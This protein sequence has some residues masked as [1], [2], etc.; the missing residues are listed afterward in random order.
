MI[1]NY[2]IKGVQTLKGGVLTGISVYLIIIL[3]L[4]IL[5][6]RRGIPWKCIFEMVFCIYGITL[7]KITGIFSLTFSL[8]GHFSYSLVPFISSSIIP[9]L[10]NFILFIPYGFLLPLV[11]YSRRWNRKKLYLFAV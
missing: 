10:L 6:I 4:Y 7:L 3:L 8:C 2:L 11:F 1:T 5:K 9:V